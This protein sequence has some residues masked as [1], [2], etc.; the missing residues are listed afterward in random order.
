MNPSMIVEALSPSTED[1][2]QERDPDANWI[3][4][5]FARTVA[6]IP[7]ALSGIELP[8]SEIYMGVE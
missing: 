1:E 8:G 5:T 6:V 4:T 2:Y 3:L 7:I